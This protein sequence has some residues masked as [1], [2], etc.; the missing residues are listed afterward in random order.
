MDL[1]TIHCNGQH[2]HY[3]VNKWQHLDT[4]WYIICWISSRFVRPGWFLPNFVK[5]VWWF[6]SSSNWQALFLRDILSG[7]STTR[8]TLNSA[9]PMG[10]CNLLSGHSSW[11]TEFTEEEVHATESQN[12]VIMVSCPHIWY[13]ILCKYQHVYRSKPSR[14]M[15]KKT[16]HFSPIPGLAAAFVDHHPILG[17][18]KHL[19]SSR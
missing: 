10:C 2:H 11:S 18:W 8:N 16:R 4:F 15:P 9:H 12:C 7:K 14:R 1:E 19:P 6:H 17:K 5:T 13:A 3:Q